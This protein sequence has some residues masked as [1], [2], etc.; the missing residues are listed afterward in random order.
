LGFEHFGNQLGSNNFLYQKQERIFDL[1]LNYDFWKYRFSDPA[2]GKFFEIDPLS[3]SYTYNSPYAFQENKFGKGV[4]L[5]GKEN[6]P[7]TPA[8]P[9]SMLWSDVGMEHVPNRA[10]NIEMVKKGSIAMAK[11]AG[12]FVATII[13]GEILGALLGPVLEGTIAGE[14][15]GIGS[16]VA[17][18]D[19][20]LM[21]TGGQE[22]KS[23]AAPN[24]PKVE[25]VIKGSRAG[26]S[27]SPKEKN[28]VIESNS[29]KNNGTVV[30]ENCNVNTTKPN[31]SQKG[32]SPPKTDRQVDHKIPKSK[33]GSATEDN[34]QVL[35]R[36][37]NRTKS[38]N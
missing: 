5:E 1:G 23:A 26:K 11:I 34:G 12:T 25:N 32:V 31:K 27:F 7:F 14:I 18:V 29:N 15:L 22:A 35:C 36:E 37:C 6:I 13:A 24:L 17:K 19:G 21:R 9:S 30:C 2:L 38:N 10:E 20:A 33:G 28:K 8:T 16:N 4:E 3:T